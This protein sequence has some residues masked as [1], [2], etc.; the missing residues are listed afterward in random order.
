MISI[1]ITE[2]AKK[3]I[4]DESF[5]P[6]FGA[7]PIK[8]YVTKNIDTLVATKSSSSN[9]INGGEG[10]FIPPKKIEKLF[11]ISLLTSSNL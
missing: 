6:S 11:K 2:N 8:R 5:D 9:V 4:I 1:V 10:I 3:K 7:R